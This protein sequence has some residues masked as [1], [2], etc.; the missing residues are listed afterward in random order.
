MKNNH[1]LTPEEWAQIPPEYVWFAIDL[2][3]SRYAYTR[4]P[5]ID[6]SDVW[7]HY[8]GEHL[9]LGIGSKCPDWQK[10][11]QQRP[12][13]NEQPETTPT[14][15]VSHVRL[16]MAEFER[17]AKDFG[18]NVRNCGTYK[19]AAMY[20]PAGN[21]SIVFAADVPVESESG[22]D[23]TGVEYIVKTTEIIKI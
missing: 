8:F 22:F 20:N 17:I 7:V 13:I 9:F 5:E 21:V 19:D 1:T 3:G 23:D 14:L 16:P 18:L 15:P 10:S 4:R 12:T 2:S 11:L 6:G